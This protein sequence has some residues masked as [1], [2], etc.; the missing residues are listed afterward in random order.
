[1]SGMTRSA[2]GCPGRV[3]WISGLSEPSSMPG[4]TTTEM[5]QPNNPRPSISTAVLEV[6][7]EQVVVDPIHKTVAVVVGVHLLDGVETLEVGHEQVVIDPVHEP[8][9]VVV[10]AAHGERGRVAGDAAASAD[11]DAVK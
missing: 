7:H 1:M 8:V 3:L 11:D 5:V 4:G 9:A 2:I 6:G 10:G